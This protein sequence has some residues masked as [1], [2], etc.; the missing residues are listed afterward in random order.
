MKR[1]TI[2]RWTVALSV[3]GATGFWYG[4]SR[5]QS[6]PPTTP[7]IYSGYIEDSG[8]P[9][10]GTRNI[11]L[12]LWKSTDTSTTADRVC[13]QAAASTTVSAGWFSIQLDSSCLDAV[14][15][16][17]ALYIE[18]VVDSTSFPLRAIGAVPY[19]VRSF[20]YQSGS[21]LRRFVRTAADGSK[22]VIAGRWWDS[23]RDE[24]CTFNDIPPGG[25]PPSGLCL[26]GNVAGGGPSDPCFQDSGC[27]IGVPAGG[28]AV[29]A[30][31]PA[32]KYVVAG[33]AGSGLAVPGPAVP[34]WC[35]QYGY[36]PCLPGP[37]FYFATQLLPASDFVSWQEQHE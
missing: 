30:G 29:P 34:S 7:V 2:V 14:H 11:G 6:A 3:V 24:E 36:G 19:A 31:S 22:E 9:V 10:N 5:A 33:G 37:T 28:A 1:E 32:P 25:Q 17:P 12:N 21:R 27:S 20:E 16:Y 13:A 18:F 35:K 4:R 26:P 23:L 15:R 8:S